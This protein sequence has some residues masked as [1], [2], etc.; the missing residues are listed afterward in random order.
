MIRTG[1]DSRV[2][3]YDI[4]E[5]QLPSFILDENPKAADFL[6]QYYIS[7]EYQGGPTDI[8]ENLDQYLKFNI[9]QSD[10]VSTREIYL[11]SAIGTDNKININVNSTKG[12]PEKY[13]LLKIDDEIITYTGITPT[14]FL[15]CQRGFSGITDYH[16]DLNEEELVFET[17]NVQSHDALAPITNLS[18][19]FIKEFFKKLKYTF[20]PG[21]EELEFNSNLNIGNFI[22][23]IRSFYQSKG[24]EESFKIL[25]KVLYGVDAT[26][27]NLENF[28]LKPSSAEYV[29]R[30]VVLIEN[31]SGEPNNLVG[32]TIQKEND[33]TTNASVSEVEVVTRNFKKYYKLSLFVGYDDFSTVKGNFIITPKSKCTE[34]ISVGSSIISVDS[35]I[36][37]DESGTLISGDN[38]ITY[39]SKSVNQFFGCSG[40]NS[41]IPLAQEIRSNDIYFGYENGDRSKPVT[42]T[43]LGS[44]SKFKQVSEVLYGVSEGDSINIKSVGDPLG[45][46][47]N[48]KTSFKEIFINSWLYNT[49]SRWK[50]KNFNGP[51]SLNLSSAVLK[52]DKT[53]FKYGDAVEIVERGTNNIV[54]TTY[55]S[56]EI[57]ENSTS[58][59]IFGSFIPVNGV[60]Y[61]LRRKINKA[62]S[63]NTPLKFGND[64]IVSDISNLYANKTH[65]YVASNSLPSSN[66]GLSIPYNYQITKKLDS[67][68]IDDTSGTLTGKEDINYSI[69]V[70]ENPISFLTGDR[71]YYQPENDSLVGLDEGYYFVE[72]VSEDLKRIKL[73]SSTSFIGTENYQLFRSPYLSGLGKHTF[74]LASQKS[75]VI[76]PQKLLRKF[77]LDINPN[78]TDSSSKNILPGQI[79]LLI[80]GVEIDSYKSQDKI[81][82]GPLKSVNIL[83]SGSNYDVINLPYIFVDN[84]FGNPG[85][86]AKIQPVISGSVEKIYVEP[87]N[88]D[89][90]KIVSIGI[91][92][93]NGRGAI[94]EPILNL[95]VREV[96]FD[97]RATTSGGGINTTTGQLTFN[98]DHN[99][100]DG[101]EIF[102]NVNGN[103][104]IG[105]GIGT[106]TLVDGASYYPKS[107][108][109]RTVYLYPSFKDYA[110]GINTIKF[111]TDNNFGIHKFYTKSDKKTLT[112]I[113]ILDGGEGYTNRKL[114]VKPSGISTSSNTIN[115]P[116]HGFKDGDLVTYRYETSPII[117]ISTNPDNQFY[118]LKIDENSFRI[119]DAGING[120]VI[121]DYERKNH[122][123]FKNQ[124]SG[125]QY[126]Q[127]PDISVYVEFT[128]IGIA[129]ETQP[130]KVLTVTPSVK[131]KIIDAY[132]Y[133][134]GT[135][136]GSTT[137]N[138]EKKPKIVI[139]NGKEA[140]VTPNIS[141]GRINT[142]KI[143]YG[144]LEYFSIPDIIAVDPSGKGSGAEFIP[145]I[146]NGRIKEIKVLNSGIGYSSKTTI[147]VVSSGTNALFDVKIRDLRLNNTE[148]FGSENYTET[149][150]N[151]LK[152]SILSYSETL[153]NSFNDDGENHSKIIGWAYDG[154][155]IYGA[156]GYSDPQNVNS[157][158]KSLVS[159]YILNTSYV[160]RPSYPEGFFVDD[161]EYNGSGDLDE[162]N[163]RFCKTPEFPLGTYAYFSPINSISKKSQFPYFI[164][165]SFKSNIIEENFY[166]D[167]DIFDFKGEKVLR[168]TYPYKLIDP[169]VENDFLSSFYDLKNQVVKVRSTSSGTIDGYDF[170]SRG[171]NYKINDI[172]T[173]Q[174]DSNET[175][176]ARVSS[177]E[178]NK[179]NNITC[180]QQYYDNVIIT[181]VDSQRLK[182]SI[183]PSH[184]IT[185]NEF[186]S[187]VGF[188]TMIPNLDGI[189][190][191]GISTVSTTLAKDISPAASIGSTEI[192]VSNIPSDIVPGSLIGIGTETVTVLNTYRVKNII[193]I[194][195][196]VTGVAHTAKTQVELIPNSFTINK[197]LKLDFDSKLN[198]K[199][200]FNPKKSIG[201]GTLPGNS[202]STSFGFADFVVSRDIPT[203]SIHIEN[204]PFLTNQK[205]LFTPPSGTISVSTDGTNTFSIPL[206]GQSEEL[207]IVNKSINS[208]GLKTSF[209]SPELFF[210]TNGV[211]DDTYLLETEFD[212]I[213]GSIT[214][215]RTTVSTAGTH[216]LSEGDSVSLT[217]KPGLNVGIGTSTKIRVSYDETY[218]KLLFDTVGFGSTAVSVSQFYYDKPTQQSKIDTYVGFGLTVGLGTTG[219]RNAQ[220][221]YDYI[222][223]NYNSFDLDGDGVVSYTD[224]LIASRQMTAVK[225]GV[226]FTGDS[227]IQGIVFPGNAT[228]KTADEIRSHIDSVTN[229]VG[230]GSTVFDINDSGVVNPEID[231]ELLIRFSSTVGLGKPGTYNP[232][233]VR[234][235][236]RIENHKF[237]S[238]DKVLY[239]NN[240]DG[241]LT[242][243][244]DGEY[245][246]IYSD[247]NNIQLALT[248]KDCIG[249]SPNAISI[250]FTGSDSQSLS[251]INPKIEVIKNNILNFDL[252]DT[253]LFGYNFEIYYDK[254]FNHKFTSTKES[255]TFSVSRVGTPG[256]GTNSSLVIDCDD[257]TPRNLYYSIT[258]NDIPIEP[259]FDAINHSSIVY[260]DSL[261]I[262]NTNYTISGIGSTTFRVFLER[263]PEKISYD[264]DECDVLKYTTNSKSASG[265]I[266]QI[267]ITSA[268]AIYNNVPILTNIKTEN[269]IDANITLK[270]DTIGD[271]KDVE[272]TNEGFSY[273]SDPTLQPT[274]YIS[275]QIFIK[276][277]NGIKD[278]EI[279]NGGSNYSS[280][281][282]I[283]I[284]DVLSG[285]KLDTG[286]LR[287]TLSGSSIGS[288]QIEQQPK[289]L[290]DT[291]IKLIT[292]NNS[293]GFSIQRVSAYTSSVFDVYISQPT[294]GFLVPPFAPGDEVFIENI[295]ASETSIGDGFN[296]SDYGY[297]FFKVVDFN[298][299]GLLARI[300]IDAS[301]F[302]EEVGEPR[303]IQSFVPIIT[304]KKVYPE[305]KINKQRLTFAIG[306]KLYAGGS[307]IDLKI[308][309]SNTSY[310]KVF[311]SY[312][313]SVNEVITGRQSG[314]VCTISEIKENNAQFEIDYST[315]VI[316]GWSN[317][318]GK[319]NNDI[320][321]IPDNDYYQNLSY[322]IKSPIN[323][324]DSK[325]VV[326]NF[327]HTIGTKN[328]TDTGITSES[329][330]IMSSEDSTTVIKDYISDNRVDTI[331]GFDMVR[332]IDS[333]GGY[334]NFLKFDSKLLTPY[335]KNTSNRVLRIDNINKQFSN[336]ESNLNPYLD[337]LNITTSNNQYLEVLV[338][339][340]DA[341]KTKVQLSNFIIVDKGEDSY[342]LE[343]GSIVSVGSSTLEYDGDKI[344]DFSLETRNTEHYLR[345][346]PV[347]YTDTD[348]DIKILQSAF[349]SNAIGIAS[350]T[351]GFIKQINSIQR[352]SGLSTN[353]GLTTN[354]VSLS[355]SSVNSI[356]A[357]VHL[358]DDITGDMQYSELYITHDGE[359]TYVS[360]LYFD[361]YG[362]DGNSYSSEL[363]GSFAVNLESNILSLDFENTTSQNNITVKTSIVGFGTTS[364]GIGTYRFKKA[365][366][367][368]GLERSAFYTSKF[369]QSTGNPLEVLNESRIFVNAAK[370]IVEV[371]I[372]ST[373]AV[374][375]LL[376]VYDGTS[377]YV[378][379]LP[380]LSVSGISTADTGVG[381]GTFGG[382][383]SGDNLIVSFY[384]DQNITGTFKVSTFNKVLYSFVDSINVAPD[385]NY[386]DNGILFARDSVGVKYYNSFNGERIN[387]RDFLMFSNELPIFAREIDTSDPTHINLATG[388]I[389]S[390]KHFF[391]ENEELIYTPNS[392]IAGIGSTALLYKSGNVIGQLPETVYVVNAQ[393][394]SFQISTTRSG[395]AVT[396]LHQGEG[397]AHIFEMKKKNE[398][399]VLTIDDVIQYPIFPKQIYHQLSNSITAQQTTFQMTGISTVV[400]KNILKVD[401]EYMNVLTVGF[402]TTSVGPIVGFGTYSLVTV[403]RGFLGTASTS[404]SAGQTASVNVGAFNIVGNTLYFTDPPRGN[405]QE[406][407]DA[408]NLDSIKS[409]FTGR[410]FLRQDY[411][412]NIIYDD[413][414]TQFNGVGRTFSLTVGSANTVGL[415]TS[416]GNGLL[417][418]NGL[419]QTPSTS[420]NPQNNFSLQENAGITS[421]VFSSIRQN[422]DI[423]SEYDINQNDRPRGGLIV[424]LGSNLGIG[425]AP[426][427]GAKVKPIVSAAGTITSVVGTSYTGAPVSVS[428]A[429]YNNFSGVIEITTTEPHML[430]EN[431]LVRLVGLGFTCPSN[432]GIVSF[433]PRSTNSDL[434]NHFPIISIASST[435]FLAQAGTSTLP[436]T[437]VGYGTVYPWYD[438]NIGSGYRG[439]V[440]VAITQ[441]G[442]SGTIA[443]ITATVGA[444]GTLSFNVTNG[445]SGYS[446]TTNATIS[447]PDPSYQQL[448]VE[449]VFRVGIGSTTETGVGLLLNVEVDSNPY[450]AGGRF[451][452]AANLID[453]NLQFIADVS[454]GR[455]LSYYPSHVVPGGNQECVDD[456]KSVLETVVY[457][458]R[459]GGNDR[460]YEAA[461][462]YLNNQSLLAGEEEQSI[463]TFNV[464]R[465][466]AIDVMRN[467][468][469]V[470]RTITSGT[471]ADAANLISANKELIADVAVGRMLDQ[472]PG[473]VIPGQQQIQPTNVTYDPVSGLSTITYA[474][475]GLFVDDIIRIAPGSLTFT[476]SSDNYQTEVSYPRENDD[477]IYGQDIRIL[478]VT[479]NTFT[480]NAGISTAVNHQPTDATYDPATGISTITIPNHGLISGTRV[481]M[482]AGG[483]TFT[484]GMDNHA[485]EHTYPRATD[486]NYNTTVAIASTTT[487]TITLQLAASGPNQYYTPTDATYDPATGISTLTIGSHNLVA[488]LPVIIQ[489]NS[490]TFTCDMDGN[491][492][493]K[494]YPRPA[495][496]GKEADYASGRSISI[497]STT[498]TTI[499]LYVGISSANQYFQPTNANYN[500]TT[501]DL[502]LTIGTHNLDIGEGIVIEEG[503]L[504]FSCD[505]DNYSTLHSYPRSTDPL[506][507]N[508]STN[509]TGITSTTITI[510]V[511]DAGSAV[512]AAHSFVSASVNAVQH[513]PQS[514]HTF[515]GAATSAIQHLPQVGYTFVSALSDAIVSGGEYN[516]QFV[517]ASSTAITININRECTDDIEDVLDTIA[518]NLTY[519]G[520]DAVYDAAKI[521]V[522]NAYLAG[523]EEQ[524]I[525]AYH[526]ARDLAIEVMRNEPITIG[527]YSTKTQFIDNSIL[528]DSNSPTCATVA[529][530]IDSFVGIIT[531]A[532]GLGTL[533]ARTVNTNLYTTETQIIDN[534]V[535]GD[536]S[537]TPGVY[538]FESDCANVASAIGSYVGI[539]TQTIANVV[540]YG[541]TATIPASKTV[542]PA[543]LFSIKNF[544]V[545]RPGYSF[546]PGDIIRP[547]GLVTD[548]R[549][550]NPISDFELTVLD[551]FTDSFALWQFGNLDYIDSI[552]A[553]QDGSRLAFPLYYNGQLLSF[554]KDKNSDFD[555]RNL[556]VIFINGILQEP[557]KSFDFNGGTTFVF[558]S[559]PKKEDN[560]SIFFYRGTIGTDSALISDIPQT[561]KI[562]D[563]VQV[564]KNDKYPTTLDQDVRLVQNVQFA[565]RIETNSYSGPGIDAVN[566]RP[567]SWAKQKRDK[568][569]FGQPIYKTRE[570]IEGQVYPTT[571]LISGLTTT[572]TEIFVESAKL[573]NYNNEVAAKTFD[574]L[575]VNGI[576]TTPVNSIELLTEVQSVKGFAGVV[577]GITS[578]TG[579]GTSKAIQFYVNNL[580][581]DSFVTAGIE[582]GYRIYIYDTRVGNGVTSINNNSVI[583]IGST[584]LDSV[585]YVTSWSGVIGD[586]NVGIITCNVHP[587]CDLSGISTSGTE[588]SPVGK[589]TWGRL[590]GFSRS[591]NPIAIDLSNNI[592]DVGLTTYPTIQRRGLGLKLVYDTGALPRRL[593]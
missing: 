3:I 104:G 30:E 341:D 64:T 27:V 181:K 90:E 79:G 480:I 105:V 457:N 249:D 549:L 484:C 435:T 22:K 261:Y 567:I 274:A 43:I 10:A 38:T 232:S 48:Y 442:H 134:T 548:Y 389:L 131:G 180:E 375:Q 458:M 300:R 421:V 142:V 74:T 513:L 75:S 532:I 226:G 263:V 365:S 40:V 382:S 184:D 575:V 476:C 297:N 508:I 466:L 201:V 372:G 206:N 502:V 403:K 401:D 210:H 278:I 332:D 205:V 276:D 147:S 198:N 15:N 314:T 193:A 127:Y 286:I 456:V 150:K 551:T 464:A 123:K 284:V 225:L 392:T 292:L 237:K 446:T 253:S 192:Y 155:P 316:N 498:D 318:I 220:Q 511:G 518:F 503:S 409:D 88:F 146:E 541:G 267:E 290:P 98:T 25:F 8:A 227:L 57:G 328:F 107:T 21:F 168:N 268:K 536:A 516:H 101:E 259:D 28:L 377:V 507:G 310:I 578:T 383:I 136:Y 282:S 70:F 325:T 425:Y 18:S 583:G 113:K 453:R 19:L 357:S 103:L 469:I 493:Q 473:F 257:K 231:G 524:S 252:H 455:M 428:T 118:V 158:P 182:L 176:S 143:E 92:G 431:D 106:S 366:V 187:L 345:F 307:E 445:G 593:V 587:D 419:F 44:L 160:D 303:T 299:T 350:T 269:G 584:Y 71:I 202:I 36:G 73:Y 487:N 574:L 254:E 240:G 129:S 20:A 60:E 530:A 399:C 194:G 324:E 273:Q 353:V 135:G 450:Y 334:S 85:T 188:S 221:I 568:T 525:Y 35:T 395:I 576:S 436:H 492:T 34:T 367:P 279:V 315:R 119:C 420:N 499:T 441:S 96:L 489:D 369:A 373:K 112:E 362:Y 280:E 122:I 500:S 59:K 272:I 412:T 344:G 354:I 67:F 528:V 126:F 556:L 301:E 485:T 323:H 388:T 26:I 581:S 505:Q 588:I 228:R 196:T 223:D 178:G 462:V 370:S 359:N 432:S 161:Y 346:Y 534:T 156:Y 243:V 100:P 56:E 443:S 398:K 51:K 207:Y 189:Y 547:V 322:T 76:G 140:K 219:G 486:D 477:N 246:V 224:S 404:H 212:Q 355:A 5:S 179:V 190:K 167:Q 164:G 166:L 430:S 139:K 288:I 9:V 317:N 411:S 517:G 589:F 543:S 239:L 418:I 16:Q 248:Y 313:L 305:F 479:D 293:N 570:S 308:S 121:S 414:S 255:G 149:L 124:G 364:A 174:S 553:Y 209:D 24:T 199:V 78:L 427:V 463:Y 433:F 109:P 495:A 356:H 45:R 46:T 154:N 270:S 159:G 23:S 562:G 529:S 522:D 151:N 474:N 552:A 378:K 340:S 560:I 467:K 114:I 491:Q 29:R 520:N 358:T 394:D 539:V 242:P 566:P 400:P 14:S 351:V 61:D 585:Y 423:I 11:T 309:S 390:E 563:T 132:L 533:P 287:A 169:N 337:I 251:L 444:G 69:I 152:Y 236:I 229:G 311:G 437:Y 592:A 31:I 86:G 312:E 148:R 381:L 191:V 417:L 460:V 304:N 47:K 320:Q 321:V 504:V 331:N 580:D 89:I 483:F 542:A 247:S 405:V 452:D 99:F 108:S 260:E 408:G 116:N 459:F 177:L 170:V 526:Q 571:K 559:A 12:F 540:A 497:A 37:F 557:G 33:P 128:S 396:F 195:R 426:L 52:D 514:V 49:N 203:R 97:G 171:K 306:E 50:I 111:N 130:T 569:I 265:E 391:S 501:G 54:F 573:F 281:P 385:L 481:L 291:E 438:L 429:S 470:T 554:E 1:F 235:S 84:G 13:G 402:G 275:P 32:Q 277:S 65:A 416:G 387:R 230:I 165:N 58:I 17:T 339:V 447:L 208:I 439:P 238:G 234:G 410:V 454:V 555:I 544:T 213:K 527:G 434:E 115:F 368:D 80:N 582:T 82:Y 298:T 125:Y 215:F 342:L 521:Y 295:Q 461:E 360:E 200:Y 449:G 538:N 496:N 183:L 145:I 572:S 214:R 137:L 87:Q 471:N 488:G 509:I 72:I 83:N 329:R 204:H 157:N 95:R 468:P 319:L 523:E 506:G 413:I 558:T 63:L 94:L 472:Y 6:K 144:G 494:S 244:D 590:S 296:S 535:I 222:W 579:I 478:S 258:K 330:F 2:K 102:Y 374:H 302:T 519:G 371:S 39:T 379:Q 512:G 271:I 347:D 218:K 250:G 66:R 289:G 380:F 363:I 424:S 7:Q 422:E 577:T 406:D 110:V 335:I 393:D 55:I 386:Y 133:E 361:D 415:G 185:S 216:G 62:S 294:D 264:Y 138:F 233:K 197:T 475:H 465:D 561:I 451:L 333:F 256:I 348:Y 217:V 120:S 338:Q 336:L 510:N 482:T 537:Q 327:L 440:S 591:T 42:F 448:E 545:T 245:Y 211:Y 173:F 546:K 175:L 531:Q 241:V 163:G 141:Q 53:S 326:N 186:V 384:P 93:G 550:Q 172:L 91:N 153:Q 41:Q 397:N 564:L 283:I 4:I 349:K 352:A 262:K 117:G 81:Y 266:D 285:E 162:N 343:K 490:L 77:P 565:D 407:K 586:D 68:Y 515:V 376:T